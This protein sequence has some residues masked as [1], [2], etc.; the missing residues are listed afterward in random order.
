MTHWSS[1]ALEQYA[2]DCD[3]SRWGEAEYYAMV[4]AAAE[5]LA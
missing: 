1:E 2:G 3:R 5:G 4:S